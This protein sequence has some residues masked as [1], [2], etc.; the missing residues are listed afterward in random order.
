[1]RQAEWGAEVFAQ[2]QPML[3]GNGHKHV[4]DGGVKL[5]A[6]A[7]FN[8]FARVGHGQG[9]AVGAVTDH[10]IERIRDGKDACPERNLLAFEAARVARAVKKLLVSEHNLGSIAQKRDSN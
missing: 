4:D 5:A 1:M 9:S 2:V 10:G 6:G 7:A 3:L 8:L